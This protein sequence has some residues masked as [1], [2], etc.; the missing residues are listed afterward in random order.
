MRKNRV[1]L[2]ESDSDGHLLS[3]DG[4]PCKTFATLDAAKAAGDQIARRFV[5]AAALSFSLDFKW[6]LSDIEL[7]VASL[8][9]ES[10]R[11]EGRNGELQ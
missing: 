1:F 2:I 11:I 8:P 9:S 5:P 10:N 7:R 6:T 3:V 4:R